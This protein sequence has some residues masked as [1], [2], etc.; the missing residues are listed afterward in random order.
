MKKKIFALLLTGTLLCCLTACNITD[1]MTTPTNTPAPTQAATPTTTPTETPVPTAAPTEI[2]APSTKTITPLPVTIDINNLNNCTVSVS[3]EKGDIYTDDAGALQM[4]V[5][6]YTYDL[7]D[8]V[9]I[10]MLAEGDTILLRGEEVL[11]TSLVR[12]EHGV[13]INGGLDVGGYELIT[14]DNTVYYEIGYSDV[15]S[16]YELGEVVLPVSAEFTFTD[17]FDLDLG[18]VIY[19]S[20]DLTK[21]D[22][23]IPYYFNPQSTSIVIE[24]GEVIAMYRMYT[25]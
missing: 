3:F 4:K 11:I 21:E 6:V 5:V 25:P 13:Q 10:A 16:Y 17:S 1:G 19:S 15:K 12:T 14:N 7:Y 20:A 2:P 24:N 9:D 22:T 8:M 23:K 18:E